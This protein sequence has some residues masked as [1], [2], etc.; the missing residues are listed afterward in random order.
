[1]EAEM[2]PKASISLANGTKI[3]FE[4][5]LDELQSLTSHLQGQR[6]EP[7]GGNPVRF[8]ERP[9][10]VVGDG[11]SAEEEPDVARI[12]ALIKECDE[13]ERIDAK[14]LAE[15]DVLNRVLMCL[16][17]V[18]KYVNPMQGLTS[19]NIER[20][21]DQLG[22]RVAISHASTTLSDKARAYVTADSVR[23]RG[24]AVKYRLNRRGVEAF[25]AVLAA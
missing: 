9:T 3:E 10:A 16:W 15:R 24:A 7:T 6:N 13:A 21:T 25:E 19:G 2:A 11:D 14:V 17:V 22:V 20:I 12:V 18:H 1:M 23:K 5:T 4:G 8:G